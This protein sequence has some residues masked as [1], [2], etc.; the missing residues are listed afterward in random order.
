[1]PLMS[2]QKPT[3]EYATPLDDGGPSPG[4]RAVGIVSLVFSLVSAAIM[5]GL[6]WRLH[7]NG[8]ADLAAGLLAIGGFLTGVF[9][10]VMTEGKSK[11]ALIGAVLSL[12]TAIVFLY[13]LVASK[14]LP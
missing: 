10:R 5:V 6:L 14:V 9:G 3:L 4:E 1:M 2:D 13:L 7:D 12:A 11:A 8:V